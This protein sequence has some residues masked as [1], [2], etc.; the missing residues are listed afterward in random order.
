MSLQKACKKVSNA[1][2]I[3]EELHDGLI[4][5]AGPRAWCDTRESWIARAA[6]RY[7]ISARTARS[8]FYRQIS[9]PKWSV[10]EAIRNALRERDADDEQKEKATADELARLETEIG[11]LRAALRDVARTTAAATRGGAGEQG[12]GDSTMGRGEAQ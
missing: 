9:D 8:I 11:E 12:A 5:L 6:R 1:A 2:D 4:K 3:R 7:G 10:V